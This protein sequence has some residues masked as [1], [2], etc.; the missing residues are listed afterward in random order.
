MVGQGV[1]DWA[2]G[3]GVII[4][5]SSMEDILDW[6]SNPSPEGDQMV[7]HSSVREEEKYDPRMLRP[8]TPTDMDFIENEDPYEDEEPYKD[9]LYD[10]QV[11]GDPGDMLPYPN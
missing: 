1:I 4:R 7:P 11:G 6:F 5:S 10:G 2:V 3:A 8:P 9:N